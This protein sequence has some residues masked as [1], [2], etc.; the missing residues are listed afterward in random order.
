MGLSF[1][2][3]CGFDCGSECFGLLGWH[4]IASWVLGLV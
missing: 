4:D 2:W 3:F 1:C